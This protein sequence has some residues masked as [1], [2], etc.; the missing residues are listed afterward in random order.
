MATAAHATTN[1]ERRRS[2]LELAP[3]ELDCMNALWPLG[4][5]TVKQVQESLMAR[6]PRAYTTIM[7]ILDRLAQKGIVSRRK[8]GRA[9]L[10]RASLQPAEAQQSAVQHLVAGFF[11][12][13][14]EAL[15]AHLNGVQVPLPPRAARISPVA[16]VELVKLEEAPR[17]AAVETKSAAALSNADSELDR[18]LL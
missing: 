9:Y 8:V 3:F 11:G 12:G 13:S 4:E 17:V 6:R 2:I 7:T 1:G 5:A 10:Y 16:P 14:R 15:A 18:T